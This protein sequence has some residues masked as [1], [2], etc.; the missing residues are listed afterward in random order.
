MT[1]PLLSSG[2]RTGRPQ[3]S[4]RSVVQPSRRLSDVAVI[5]L[6]RPSNT[7]NAR[8]STGPSWLPRGAETPYLGSMGDSRGIQLPPADPA[9]LGSA[10]RAVLTEQQERG[11]TL[12]MGRLPAPGRLKEG[13]AAASQ[14]F[15]GL[16]ELGYLVASADG[17]AGT[18]REALASLLEH[19]SGKSI[20]REAVLLHFR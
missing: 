5:L 19:V 17:L 7:V 11:Q 1:L 13:A 15:Q 8:S 12:V 16:L 14:Y 18:E 6:H 2:S 9:R 4:F 10:V 20:D 3:S